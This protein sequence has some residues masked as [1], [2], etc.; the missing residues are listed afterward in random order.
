MGED[1]M[2]NIKL[3]VP[4]FE[5]TWKS[6]GPSSLRHVLAYYGNDVDINILTKKIKVYDF[7]TTFPQLAVYA[8]KNDY[9]VRLYTYDYRIFPPNWFNLQKKNLIK[10]LKLRLKFVKK[11][12]R[13]DI[14][15]GY[16]MPWH[17]TWY[18]YFIKMF[19]L[20][21]K[22]IF[23]PITKDLIIRELKNKKPVIVCLNS[24]GHFNVKMR[25]NKTFDNVKGKCWGHFIVIAGY[26]PGKFYVINPNTKGKRKGKYYYDE[27]KLMNQII[28]WSPNMLV[29]EK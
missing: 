13:S 27:D 3:N 28:S 20:G 10:K 11:N 21:G 24:T 9:K 29:I 7:G 6:C 17:R 12:K 19:N 5:Q 14:R 16:I 15:K 22:I 26:K 23:K 8:L 18:E 25:Y 2:V 1:K 4:R